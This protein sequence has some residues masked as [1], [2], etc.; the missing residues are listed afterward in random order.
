M[1]GPNPVD[2]SVGGRIRLRRRLMKVSQERLAYD[3]GLTP[4]QVQKYERAKNGV[5]ASRIY[6]IARSLGA[7]VAYFFED[8]ADPVGDAGGDGALTPTE[9]IHAFLMT[10]EGVELARLFPQIQHRRMR[11]HLLDL[12]RDLAERAEGGETDAAAAPAPIGLRRRG[13]AQRPARTQAR[14]AAARE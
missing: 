8:L 12:V 10:P 14:A 5:S 13:G 4:Q 1:A 2:V 3:L 11:R 6:Q 7:P 9:A